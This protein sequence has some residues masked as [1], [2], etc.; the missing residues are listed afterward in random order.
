MLLIDFEEVKEKSHAMD[1]VFCLDKL[2]I[3][4]DDHIIC[5][6]RSNTEEIDKKVKKEPVE[7][8]VEISFQS[9]RTVVRLLENLSDS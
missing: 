6:H 2:E 9:L 1:P 8:F 3:L 7:L 4:A 5:L